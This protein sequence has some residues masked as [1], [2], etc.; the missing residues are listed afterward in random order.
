MLLC[1]LFEYVFVKE[2]VNGLGAYRVKFAIDGNANALLAFAHAKC[3]RKLHLVAEF[4]L[5]DEILQA[6]DHLAGTFNVT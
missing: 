5:L 1:E 4:V 3:T 2:F 6:L